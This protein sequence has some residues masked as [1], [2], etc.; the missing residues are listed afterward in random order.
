MGHDVLRLP[1][2]LTLVLPKISLAN[3]RTINT[4]APPTLAGTSVSEHY[5]LIVSGIGNV[6]TAMQSTIY[7]LNEGVAA[8]FEVA[9]P[10]K[11][12]R[13]SVGGVTLPKI[14]LPLV[15]KNQQRRTDNVVVEILGFKGYEG[16]GE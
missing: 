7:M 14:Y 3:Q 10:M 16:Y 9:P 6:P 11:S 1:S 15:L 4:S 2:L 12:E 8:Q 5:R 13:H